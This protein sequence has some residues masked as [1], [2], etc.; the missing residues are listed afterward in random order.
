[1]YQKAVTGFYTCT[2]KQ[3]TNPR[4]QHKCVFFPLVDAR[5]DAKHTIAFKWP[6]RHT[7]GLL[8]V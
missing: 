7:N 8:V 3:N 2:R 1:M 5:T 4:K 6:Y